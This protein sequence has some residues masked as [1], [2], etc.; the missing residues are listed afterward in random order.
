MRGVATQGW[1]RAAR[2]EAAALIG[3]MRTRQG[4]K[5]R[6]FKIEFEFG[7]VNLTPAWSL[8]ED[9]DRGSRHADPRHRWL[10]ERGPHCSETGRSARGMAKLA[11]W[12]YGVENRPAL[13]TG[14][15]G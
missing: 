6:G 8:R 14:L 5:S 3:A 13:A 9:G 10:K 15:P 11:A 12:A 7:S 1:K 2:R 4:N